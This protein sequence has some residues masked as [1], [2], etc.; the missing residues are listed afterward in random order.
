MILPKFASQQTDKERSAFASTHVICIIF[1]TSVTVSGNPLGQVVDAICYADW[2]RYTRSTHLWHVGDIVN[3]KG[4]RK[5]RAWG[6]VKRKGNW[7][8][9]ARL[10]RAHWSE[11][12]R[13]RGKLRENEKK[14]PRV[15]VSCLIGWLFLTLFSSPNGYSVNDFKVH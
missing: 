1:L 3:V 15:W 14:D 9:G 10:L 12:W 2:L 5:S 11:R 8:N 4:P 7:K 13:V 6:E